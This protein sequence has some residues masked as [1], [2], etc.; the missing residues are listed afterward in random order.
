MLEWLG[1]LLLSLAGPVIAVGSVQAQSAKGLSWPS[2]WVW[3]WGEALL[4]VA[5][6]PE[7]L[8]LLLNF[9]INIVSIIVIGWV[10]YVEGRRQGN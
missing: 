4:F 3:F 8:P 1:S 9:G 2:L 10:K 6:F 7:H 5:L